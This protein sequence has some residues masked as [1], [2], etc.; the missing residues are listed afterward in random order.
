MLLFTIS[1][2][3]TTSP[4]LYPHLL[5]YFINFGYNQF[6]NDH[7]PTQ[8]HQLFLLYFVYFSLHTINDFPLSSSVVAVVVVD[9]GT[10][11][12]Y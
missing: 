4:Y 1:Y 3:N 10:K 12:I 5:S 11:Y 9:P 8:T 2:N 6:S 7:D